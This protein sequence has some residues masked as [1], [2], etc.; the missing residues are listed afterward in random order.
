MGN[1]S[2]ARRGQ[3]EIVSRK[4]LVQPPPNKDYSCQDTRLLP[5]SSAFSLRHKGKELSVPAA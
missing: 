2:I 5:L 3:K 1:T 4:G